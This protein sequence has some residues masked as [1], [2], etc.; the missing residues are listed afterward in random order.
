M[1]AVGRGPALPGREKMGTDQVV[2]VVVKGEGQQ[3]DHGVSWHGCASPRWFASLSR[4]SQLPP[5]AFGITTQRY[6]V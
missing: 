2:D 3:A 4:E 1:W 6:V 5:L